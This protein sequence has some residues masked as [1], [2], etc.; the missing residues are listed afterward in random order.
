MKIISIF[1]AAAALV[2]LAQG[3]AFANTGCLRPGQIQS[4]R[5]IDK[6][7]LIVHQGPNDDYKVTLVMACP[8][9]DFTETIGFKK[10]GG[11]MCMS[12]GDSIVY[13][14]GGMTQN[15]LI[16]AIKPYTAPSKD[17]D[18]AKGSTP[19]GQPPAKPH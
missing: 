19:P 11:M 18:A 12:Q 4:W 6:K 10:F 3:P 16:S 1:L 7:T 9:L 17:K 8:S 14:H 5:V 15:C 2:L 13:R